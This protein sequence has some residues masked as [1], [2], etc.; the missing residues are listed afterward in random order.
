MSCVLLIYKFLN[1]VF[2]MTANALTDDP[3]T[4]TGG[5]FGLGY[6][7]GWGADLELLAA[8]LSPLKLT[9]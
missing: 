9:V 6:H 4:V 7:P 3:C 1:G 5:F 2:F 8:S